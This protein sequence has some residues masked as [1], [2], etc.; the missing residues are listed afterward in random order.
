[1]ASALMSA[2]EIYRK[3]KS[4]L[5]NPAAIQLQPPEANEQVAEPVHAS[6]F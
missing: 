3:K 1:M 5:N 4:R 2:K 6:I